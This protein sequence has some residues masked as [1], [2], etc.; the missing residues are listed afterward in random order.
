M[1]ASLYNSQNAFYKTPFGAVAAGEEIRFTISVPQEFGCKTPYLVIRRDGEAQSLLLLTWAFAQNGR[2]IFTLPYTPGETGLYF[3]YFDL[4]TDYRKLYCGELGEAYIAQGEGNAYQLT[5]YDKA[6]ETP[7]ALRGGVMYQIFPDRFFEGE[8]KTEMP[9]SDRIYREDKENEPYFWPNEQH[10]GYLNMDYFGGDFKG[11]EAKL[12][13]LAALGVSVLYLNPIFE[14]HANHRY[15]VADYLHTDPL[16]GD[17]WAFVRL[18]DAAHAAGMKI[19][20]DGVFSHTGSDS[21][22]FNKEGR[23]PRLGAWQSEN[24][25]YRAWYM[26]GPQYK[27]GYRSWWGF[28]TLP[29]VDENNADFREFICGENGVMDYWL[30]LGADGFRLDVADELPDDFIAA[31]RK[32]VKRRGADKYL[33]GEVWDDASNKCSYGARRQYLLGAELDSVM[34]YPIKDAV[35]A[36]LTGGDAKQIAN[37]LMQ[38]CENYPAPALHTLM[39]FISTHDTVRGITALAGERVGEHDRYWQSGRRLSREQYLH[40]RRLLRLAYAMIYTL[41]GIPSIYYGDEICTEGYKDPFNRSYFNW[42]SEERFMMP[43][44]HTLAQLR[45][46]HA[47]FRDGALIV[48]EATGGF[49]H[50]ERRCEGDSVHIFINR[51]HK[52]ETRAVCGS[53]HEINSLRYLICTQD[54]AAQDAACAA[55]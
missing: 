4:Y 28:E 27:H 16:L 39:N 9:Y 48:H 26:F 25:I 41:P 45:R 22:Y 17:N 46:E 51:T 47:A 53:I 15:N 7:A 13:Y 24:S 12:P 21:I 54:E 3:Y 30:S 23:Y 36:F 35:L 6:F 40:G 37:T 31:L 20:L 11:I 8:A 55:Q 34:N 2:D 1:D 52:I 18:C 44:L 43:T 5:V 49:L 10:E 14:S 50:Y 33:L 19:I 38:I 42:K 29:E 32:A